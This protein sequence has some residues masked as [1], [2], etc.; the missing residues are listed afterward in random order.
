MKSIP[1]LNQMPIDDFSHS[2]MAD[3]APRAINPLMRKALTAYADGKLQEAANAFTCLIEDASAE[4]ALIDRS[5]RRH[6]IEAKHNIL[7]EADMYPKVVKGRGA[8]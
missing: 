8:Q 3:L 5:W 7:P 2:Q 1:S 6:F 4:A